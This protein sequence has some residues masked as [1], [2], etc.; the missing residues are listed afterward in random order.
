M[1]TMNRCPQC[2]SGDLKPAGGRL[3][4]CA[5]C[6]QALA[7]QTPWF[8]VV[9]TWALLGAVLG[10]GG[11]FLVKRVLHWNTPELWPVIVFPVIAVI[12][13]FISRR[14]RTLRKTA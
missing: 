10:G 1:A 5:G 7:Y 6:G 3:L 12:S 13:Y 8:V 2:G 4:R 14:F 11:F 9:L